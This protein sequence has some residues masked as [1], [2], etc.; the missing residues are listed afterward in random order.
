MRT[1]NYLSDEEIRI[2]IRKKKARRRR[3]I[4][5]IFLAIVIVLCFASANLIG[6]KIGNSRYEKEIETVSVIDTSVPIVNTAVKQIGN[7][8]GGPFWSWY[9]F[10][11]RVAW[12]ACFV[13]WCEDQNGYI[14]QGIAPRFATTCDG[15]SWFKSRKQWK[16]RNKVPEAG[17]LVFFDWEQDGI[18]DHVGIVAGTSDDRIYTVE[19]NSTDMCRIKSYEI[20]DKVLI[21]YGSIRAK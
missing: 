9:G 7:H 8:G 21:G 14:S 17:D 12:C 13:S 16:R 19:G 5:T 11:G 10:G 2:I 1:D 6:K 15:I 3:I 20:G 4:C 18:D